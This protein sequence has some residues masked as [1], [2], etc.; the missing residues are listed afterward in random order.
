MEKAETHTPLI[1]MYS[2]YGKQY[3]NSSKTNKQAYKQIKKIKTELPLSSNPTTNYIQKRSNKYS[4]GHLP[5]MFIAA[6]FVI[7]KIWNQPVH[8][9]MNG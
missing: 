1:K 2:H 4:K 3:G 6:L 8:Q 7:D 5:P 9:Q